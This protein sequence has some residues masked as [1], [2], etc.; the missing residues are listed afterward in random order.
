M[1]SEGTITCFVPNKRN[2]FELFAQYI[3]TNVPHLAHSFGRCPIL[4]RLNLNFPI[5]S[6]GH[7]ESFHDGI[8]FLFVCALFEYKRLKKERPDV[9]DCNQRTLRFSSPPI[10]NATDAFAMDF[11]ICILNSNSCRCCYF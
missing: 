6:T 5:N 10:D 2:Y 3:K 1:C 9:T 7:Q 8:F 4:G 11:C